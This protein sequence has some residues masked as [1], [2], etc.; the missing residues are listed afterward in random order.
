[1]I[2]IEHLSDVLGPLIPG[3]SYLAIRSQ[4]NKTLKILI[5]CYNLF[6]RDFAT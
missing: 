4:T 5:D 2:E 1:M 3:Q 6:D